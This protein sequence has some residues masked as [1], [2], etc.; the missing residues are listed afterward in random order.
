MTDFVMGLPPGSRD[1]LPPASRNR[2]HL[3]HRLIGVFERWG[4]AQ[5]M[6]P[7]LEYYDVLARGLSAE[8]RRQCVRFIDPRGGAVIALRSDF[9][10]QIARMAALRLPALEAP[11][12][13]RVSYADELVRLPEGERDS[14]E[15]HQ[16]G[17]ELVGDDDPAADAELIALCHTALVESGLSEFRI[18][19]SHR[20]VVRT[21]L[22]PLGLSEAS[23]GQVEGLLARKDRGGVLGL[24][25]ELGVDDAK[26]RAA[27]SLCSLYG[28]AKVLGAAEQAL[29]GLDGGS[30]VAGLR[31]VLEQLEHLDPVASSRIDVDLGEVR[32]FEYYTGL[33][34]R[35]WAPGVPRPIVRG[36]R[37]DHLLG[38]YG[39]PA[40]ATGFAIDLDALEAALR[41]ADGDAEADHAPTHVVAVARHASAR[42]RATAARAAAEARSE[43][44]RAW[45]DPGLDWTQAQAYATRVGAVE[46]SF[47]DAMGGL[48]RAFHEAG[49][50][51]VRSER[52]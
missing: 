9:T 40:P 25:A 18:D 1:L 22:E 2:R 23:R 21:V 27:A 28:D 44:A 15:Q 34:M 51:I 35:V 4:F 6:T 29:A 12:T 3:T 19:L 48:R 5:A 13:L 42:A 33:R 38:R 30:A 45:V 46:L 14:A 43:G 31:A 52:A 41:E 50:W 16:A 8:D 11:K 24:L 10:P 39:T 26:A 36:G 49:R 17:V 20:E 37:Y 32:G 47:V 7:L